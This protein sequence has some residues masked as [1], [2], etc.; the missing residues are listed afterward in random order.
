[1]T[2]PASRPMILLASASPRRRR[3]LQDLG[4]PFDVAVP[5]VEEVTLDSGPERTALHNALLKNEWARGRV[6]DA[7]VLS[8]DT[9]IDF[10]GRC[11]GKPRHVEEAAAMLGAFSG[12]THRV[13]TALALA[14]PGG[15]PA[16]RVTASAVRFRALTSA[17][18]RAYLAAVDPLDKAGAYDID[19]CG[20]QVVE[21]YEGSYTNIMGLPV[22][23]LREMLASLDPGC[24]RIGSS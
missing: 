11:V 16:V 18:I 10:E 19:Q 13:L 2:I 1:M 21:S 24:G 14:G 20:E 23:T 15:R 9:V 8:A 6:C 22:E 5:D 12:R 4:L 3:I 17:D 7:V